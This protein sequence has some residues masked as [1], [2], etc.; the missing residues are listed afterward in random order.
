MI[1]GNILDRDRDSGVG[2]IDSMSPDNQNYRR[3]THGPAYA[4]KGMMGS[5]IRGR[6]LENVSTNVK[7]MDEMREFSE[8]AEEDEEALDE[9]EMK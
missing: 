4:S 3:R 2:V 6:E 9:N 1:Q 7:E 5:G 8:E